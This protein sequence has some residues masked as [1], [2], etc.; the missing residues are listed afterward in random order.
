MKVLPIGIAA[1][2]AV[3]AILAG[4][5]HAVS[6][7]TAP[8]ARK[9]ATASEDGLVDKFPMSVD[10]FLAGDYLERADVVLT[11]RD[12]DF[13]SYMIRWA[14]GSPFSHAA[15]IFTGPK[16]DTGVDH[17]FVIEAGTSGVDLTN[18]KDYATDKSSFIAIK[19]LKRDWFDQPLQSRARG[20]LLDRIKASYDYWAIGRLARNI[21]FGV[22]NT[23]QG[24][25]KTIEKYRQREWSP[26][27]E[28]ICS[29]LVQFGFIEAVIENIRQG[30]LPLTALNDVV[31]RDKAE[32]RIIPK[33]A[34][35]DL[36]NQPDM[37]PDK[38]AQINRGLINDYLPQIRETL[39]AEL[40]A[41]TPHDIATS[42]KLEWLYLV[43]NGK[44][45]KVAS[46]QEVEKLISQ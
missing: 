2:L 24:R 33:S 28:F 3:A 26:P 42:S 36:K 5:A 39:G 34:L 19:R 30:K 25:D 46:L 16:Y 12:Y 15:M 13:S 40:E 17:T 45:H 37:T 6:P 32:E 21:W 22:Q 44:V 14:T 4:A 31:F 38:W 41:T 27:N 35:D 20:V 43:K 18:L 8:A 23:V 1:L 11:R 10:K 29:G 7:S 9:K